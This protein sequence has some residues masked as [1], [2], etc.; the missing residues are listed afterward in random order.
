MKPFS[1]RSGHGL[2]WMRDDS[3]TSDDI[4]SGFYYIT[5]EG[6]L[7][8]MVAVYFGDHPERET[9]ARIRTDGTI[10]PNKPQTL[11]GNCAQRQ[12]VL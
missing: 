10:F 7:S 5:Q 12:H 3:N 6:R 11:F 1:D 8:P 2:Q 9:W 4:L